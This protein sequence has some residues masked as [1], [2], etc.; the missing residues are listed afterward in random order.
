MRGKAKHTFHKQSHHN[1]VAALRSNYP[2][3]LKAIK[4]DFRPL[5]YSFS[6]I[7]QLHQATDNREVFIGAVILLFRKSNTVTHFLHENTLSIVSEVAGMALSNS[8]L[9]VKEIAF[10][11]QHL[12]ELRE[13][14]EYVANNVL[15]SNNYCRL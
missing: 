9:E 5:K 15:L 1:I 13:R 6:L 10:R 8:S 4:A 3:V 11:L 14:C 7:P 2:D 12:A